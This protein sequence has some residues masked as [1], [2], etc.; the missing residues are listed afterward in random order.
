ME[1]RKFI[2]FVFYLLSSFLLFTPIETVA[3]CTIPPINLG[4]D[5]T[6]CS[7]QTL[8]LNAGAAG[9][10]TSYLWNN[11]STNPLRTISTP[12]TY[13][14]IGTF[15]GPNTV[16]NG[17]FESGNTGFTTNYILGTGGSWGLVSNAGTYAIATSPNLAHSNFS[18]C[19]DH[20]PTPGVNMMVV[21]GASTAN[22][23][24]WCQTVTVQPN[25]N[26]QLSTWVSNALNDINAA[27][28]QF[29]INGN[30]TGPVFTTS[31]SGCVWQQFFQI[32]NSGANSTIDICILNQNTGG[33]GNDFL[34]DDIAFRPVCVSNDTIVVTYSTNPVVNL[35]PDQFECVGATVVLDAQNP[36]L[37]YSWTGGSTGQTLAVD[38]T[39]NYQVTVTNAN[40]CS[41]SD[42]INVTFETQKSAGNDSLATWC[43]TN[44]IQDLNAYLS[45]NAN[46]GGTWWDNGS[47]LGGNLSASGQLTLAGILGNQEAMYVVYGTYCPNDTSLFDFTVHK[48]PIHVGPT[49][50]NW[51]NTVG[52]TELLLPYAT[53][54][55]VD[56]PPFWIENSVV[57]SNQFN[58]AFS[59]LDLSNLNAGTYEFDY[60]LSAQSPCVNDTTKV[61]VEITENP[62]VQFSSDLIKGCVPLEVNFI[63]QSTFEPS[64]TVIWTLEDGTIETNSVG[65]NHIFESPTCFD[66]TLG[67]LTGNSLCYTELTIPDMICVDPLPVA[68]FTSDLS[69]AYSDDPTVNFTNISTNNAYNYWSFGDSTYSYEINPEHQFPIGEVGNYQVILL[70]T[71]SEGCQDTT[72]KI[73]RVQDQLLLYVPNSFTPDNDEFNNVFQPIITAGIDPGSFKM[74]IYDRWGHLIFETNDLSIGWDGTFN[75]HPAQAGIYSWRID[76]KDEKTDERKL[77]NGHVNLMR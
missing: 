7:T 76:F 10:Y 24:V 8:S 15:L 40:F 59:A 16:V 33:S 25:T 14:V 45:A 19:N 71:S 57:P 74:S 29:S 52:V 36:G 5:T 48:Q 31:T 20:T 17:D 73:I 1:S 34:L 63:N 53:A 26:Y 42:Q 43:E 13:S 56:L 21:N 54:S 65:I 51:C 75:Q 6:L 47:A 72:S 4:P 11:N 39:G 55:V 37:T 60:V 61:F 22:T 44:G 62:I 35:G 41:S 67:I 46:A 32:W 18:S 70:V 58:T 68:E 3:Q 50:L 64:S 12:G 28:L 27:Q 66:V 9:A 69:T 2:Y 23:T 77:V 30:P 38:T 49:T